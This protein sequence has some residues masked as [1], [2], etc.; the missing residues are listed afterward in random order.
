MLKLRSQVA[1]GIDGVFGVSLNPTLFLCIT[2]YFQ[3]SFIIVF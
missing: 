2:L 3:I 1:V